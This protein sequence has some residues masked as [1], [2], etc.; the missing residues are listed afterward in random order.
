MSAGSILH[1]LNN[2]SDRG[3]I[4]RKTLFFVGNTAWSMYNF[5]LEVLKH[6]ARDYNI[7]VVAP[8]DNC[9]ALLVREGIRYIPIVIDNKGTSPVRD[10]KLLWDFY[11]LYKRHAPDYIFHYTI[12]PN[13]YG[14]LA[15][16]LRKIR[17]VSCVTGAGSV[18]VTDTWVTSLVKR[19][20]RFAFRF[21]KEVWFLN[22]DDAELF[23]S[24]NLVNPSKVKVLPGEG[25]DTEKF[26]NDGCLPAGK[27]INFLFL[28]RLLW[29]KGVGEYVAASRIILQQHDNVKFKVLGFLDVQ[30]PSAIDRSQLQQWIDEGVI[31]YLGEVTDVREEIFRADCVV[32]PSYREGVP[33]SLL[34]ASSMG[35][36]VIATDVPGCRDVVDDGVTGYLCKPQDDNDLAEK[37]ELLINVSS[38]KRREMGLAGRKKVKA[39]FEIRQVLRYYEEALNAGAPPVSQPP[40]APF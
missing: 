14:T 18:F 35:K 33:R 40:R 32:L 15:A 6:F 3:S 8:E 38:Q 36:P 31:E 22:K 2:M 39:M 27:D 11:R 19:L 29:D 5:R 1:Q 24:H 12:K 7:V 23:Y 13:I 17:S 28:G 21:P 20:F 26:R 25:I 9:A 4:G 16:A 37:F 34:E 30:N 10:L